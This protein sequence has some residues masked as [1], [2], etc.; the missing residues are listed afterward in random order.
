MAMSFKDK[1]KAFVAK[2]GFT[3]RSYVLSIL[4]LPPAGVY[5]AWKKP[6]LPLAGRLLLGATAIIAPP[7]IGGATLMMLKT[8]LDLVR[9]TFHV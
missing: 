3:Y 6:G 5:I 4:F 9:T 8:A 2:H 7:F 1:I